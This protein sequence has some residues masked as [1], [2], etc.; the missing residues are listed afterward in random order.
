MYNLI[1]IE[2]VKATVLVEEL[3]DLLANYQLFYQNLSLYFDV[4]TIMGFLN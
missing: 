3:N 4:I 1:G 2:K